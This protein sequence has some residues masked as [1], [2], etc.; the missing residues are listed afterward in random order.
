VVDDAP[1]LCFLE[2]PFQH[3]FASAVVGGV[4]KDA[5]YV[6]EHL[7]SRTAKRKHAPSAAPRIST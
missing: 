4:G 2:L 7:A 5:R 6:A 3:P 1:G